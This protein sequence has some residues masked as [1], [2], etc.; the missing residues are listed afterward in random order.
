MARPTPQRS[1]RAARRAEQR[2]RRTAP[3]TAPPPSGLPTGFT[4]DSYV[5]G[6]VPL[7]VNPLIVWSLG[8]MANG[9]TQQLVFRARVA[10]NQASGTYYNRVAVTADSISIAPTGP[11]APVVVAGLPSLIFSKSADPSAVAAGHVVTYTLDLFNPDIVMPV[12]ATMT[13]T[14]PNGF[15]YVGMISG[16]APVITTPQM[17][18]TKFQVAPNSTQ[19][20][21]YKVLVA[22]S[23]PDGTYYNQLDGSSAQTVFAGSGPTAPVLVVHSPSFDVQ[24]SKSDDAYTNT[25]GGTRVYTLYYTNTLNTLGLLARNVIVTDTFSPADYLIAD[26]PG[27][28]LAAAGVYTQAVGDLPAGASG[29]LTLGLTVDPGIPANYL[30]VTNT[31]QIGADAPADVPEATEQPATNNTSNDVDII[32]GAD[33][34]V[35]GLTYSPNN[36]QLGKIMTVVVTL[37]NRGVDATAGPDLAGWFYADLY[38][39]PISAPAPAGPADRYLGFCLDAANFPC[40]QQPAHTQFVKTYTTT[41][42]AG[43]LAPGETVNVTYTVLLSKTSTQWLYVQADPFWAQNGDPDPVTYG[44]SQDGRVVEGNEDNNIFG[45]FAINVK[46]YIY[47]PIMFRIR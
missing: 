16:T 47:L 38:V 39:K 33:I 11:V 19:R 5:S 7:S 12:T 23:T 10:N 31:A 22:A 29:W 44:S 35:L 41:A 17:I 6:A 34:A 42:G 4:W 28:N 27:W 1:T 24:I 2:D 21:I 15:N 26:A 43:G 9:S 32:R 3:V 8:S 14:L 30:A 20:L 25:L 45:P 46:A 18:W 40:T 36:L 37:Q 13:D